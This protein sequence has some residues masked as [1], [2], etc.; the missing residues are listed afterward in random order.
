MQE[1][2]RAIGPD[3]LYTIL[4]E[5]GRSIV[6]NAGL[7]VTRVEYIKITPDKNFAIIDAAMNDLIR[8]A[9]YHSF[10]DI[11]PLRRCL[12]VTER[13]Y[14]VV[15]PVC[16]SADFLGKDR[17]LAIKE[18]DYLVVKSAGAYGFSMSSNYNTRPRAAEIL[19]HKGE[20]QV[21]R[22]RETVQ[23]LFAHET[24][25]PEGWGK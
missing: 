11:I 23:D 5:P 3:F 1:V 16:E 10:H 13:Q 18:G 2:T 20:H 15:G 8:P 9:L 21:I 17:T 14:D 6:A 7:L 22:A 12:D 19:V 4:V 25:S 24:K